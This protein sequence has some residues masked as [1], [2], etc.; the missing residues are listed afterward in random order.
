MNANE[1]IEIAFK[2]VGV[3]P[4]T[5]ITIELSPDV[6]A[7]LPFSRYTPATISANNVLY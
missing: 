2:I 3:K 7:S 6:G 4:N 1:R 5:K